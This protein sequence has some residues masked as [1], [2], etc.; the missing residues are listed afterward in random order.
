V[1]LVDQWAGVEASLPDGWQ[2][3]R[4]TLTTEQPGELARA[5]QVLGPMNAGR[6]GD[7]LVVDVRRAGG[8]SGPEAARRL[9]SRLDEDRVWC[10]LTAG[11]VTSAAATPARGDSERAVA[12]SVAAQ[13]DAALSTLPPDWSDLLCE[14]RLESSDLLPRAALLGAPLNPTRDLDAIGFVFRCARRAGYG[15]SPSMARRCFERLDDE[16]IPAGVAIRRVISDARNVDTQ[17]VVWLV[18]GRVL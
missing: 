4:L 3:I 9:F 7:A 16:A 2:E 11:D 14:L 12:E 1:K 10:L 6:A 17:G 15:V 13:W 8:A 5:A 18:D